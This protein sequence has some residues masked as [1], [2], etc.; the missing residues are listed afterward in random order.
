MRPKALDL[1]CCAGG[2]AMGLHR[3]GFDVVGVDLK[4]QPRYPFTFHQADAMAF[5]LDGFDFVWAS[6]PCQ[7]YSALK[8]MKNAGDHPALVPEVRIKLDRSGIPYAIENV[9]GAPLLPGKTIM[10]C[11]TMFG[12]QSAC[13]NG[14]LRRHRYFETRLP[15]YFAASVQS[16]IQDYARGIW[17]KGAR[18][19]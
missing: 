5:P 1:F 12:L 8:V 16:L 13:G 10:L 18:H 14:E 17:R 6:P 2:A 15:D 9:F 11:G 19:R 4:P 7:S 3:A